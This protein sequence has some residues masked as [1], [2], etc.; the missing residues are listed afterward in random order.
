MLLIVHINGFVASW[1]LFHLVSWSPSG[2]YVVTGSLTHNNNLYGHHKNRS[3][4][5]VWIHYCKE[6]SSVLSSNPVWSVSMKFPL[7]L[8]W[9]QTTP[10]LISIKYEVTGYFSQHQNDVKQHMSFQKSIKNKSLKD[11]RF[12]LIFFPPKW[13]TEH[14]PRHLETEYSFKITK[15]LP[16]I[17]T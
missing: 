17:I 6:L 7:I 2:R 5:L 12:F 11:H 9:L 10:H 15:K 13:I 3:Q 4:Y 8:Y 16:V 1:S 14:S